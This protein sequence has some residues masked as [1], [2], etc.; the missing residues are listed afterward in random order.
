MV[1][2]RESTALNPQ[3]RAGAATRSNIAKLFSFPAVLGMTLMVMLALFASN[4]SAVRDVSDPDIW[5]HLAN[6]KRLLSTHTFIHH[7]VFS[8]TLAGQPWINFEWLAELPF[9]A[10]FRMF[11]LRGLFLVS[12]ALSESILLGVYLLCYMH[13]LDVKASFLAGLV[14]VVLSCISLGPRTLLFGWLFLVI[15]LFVLWGYQQGRNYIWTLPPLFLLW[16]NMHG[17]WLLGFIVLVTFALCAFIKGEWGAVTSPGLSKPM[18]IPLL[19]SLVAVIGTLFCNPYG[20]RLPLYPFA[21]AVSQQL[22]VKS[23]AEWASLDLHTFF[24]KFLFAIIA[25][26]AITSLTRKRM[27]TLFDLFLVLFAV[28]CG[29][30]YT[31]FIFMTGL[32]ISP[33]LA[34]ELR[35][36]LG[37]YERKLERPWLNA[38]A[39]AAL[40]TIILWRVPSESDLVQHRDQT[41]PVGAL[42]RLQ[43][44]PSGH[45]F[46]AYEWGGYMIYATP[47]TPVFIDSRADL[48]VENGVFSDYLSAIQGW[49]SFETLKK[50]DIRYVLLPP[51]TAMSYL[52]EHNTDWHKRYSDMH[53]VLFELVPARQ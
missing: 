22:N 7:D 28:F 40:A 25:V 6:A 20:W 38:L 41:F 43:K 47:Q 45:V 12:L 4:G 26:L 18:R 32:V 51:D 53:S 13:S 16:V 36:V 23:V 35:G 50:Y 2:P 24:G 11:G 42:A 48:F 3:A 30:T 39:L 49:Q 19:W 46:N 17:S 34:I 31:R 5:W 15:E 21:F 52:L 27:W 29:L 37:P 9:Y 14:A 8:F 44:M 33:F 10:A 1:E